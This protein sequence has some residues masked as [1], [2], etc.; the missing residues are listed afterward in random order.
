[1]GS[2]DRPGA[3]YSASATQV[4]AQPPSRIA[5]R[6]T[7][8]RA[9]APVVT[10]A[11][12]STVPE[13]RAQLW[14]TAVELHDI[15]G[16][17]EAAAT[18][19]DRTA[20]FDALCELAAVSAH[21][22]SGRAVRHRALALAGADPDLRVRALTCL[23]A[24]MIWTDLTPRLD[25]AHLRRGIEAAL[26]RTYPAEPRARLLIAAVLASGAEEAV[27]PRYRRACEALDL[28]YTLG[29]PELICAALDAVALTLTGPALLTGWRPIADELTRVAA[30]CGARHYRA[31]AQYLRFRAACRDTDLL[32][33]FHHAKHALEL[34]RGGP[35]RTQLDTLVAFAATVELLRG[36]L[37]A[38]ARDYREFTTRM[39]DSGVAHGP[40]TA[41][42]G[43]CAL[44]WA[45]GEFASM[46]DR[47]AYA[48]AAEPDRAA[49][50]YALALALAGD[51]DEARKLFHRH[52][53]APR[54]YFWTVMAAFRAHTA[55]ALGEVES[56]AL[57][58]ESLLP[59]SGTILGFDT[60]LAVFG[61]ADEVLAELAD[62]LGDEE[63]ALILR[64]R[65]E[66]VRDRV[67]AALEAIAA[68]E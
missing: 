50:P 38:A 61:P 21:D 45:K 40:S 58:Y 44:A 46:R 26:A 51:L 35:L 23:R 56:A 65:A 67:R 5:Q 13:R 20:M 49:Q 14:F 2:H 12:D 41:L 48:Y 27:A 32:A 31:L 63:S 60:G 68:G 28:A 29:D 8:A 57:L 34:A 55:I 53:V 24:P 18:T 64:G 1:M 62:L 16:H 3:S 4:L 6:R 9:L 36:D 30:A 47:L 42:I 39:S 11:R 25:N 17:S 54:Q 59:H 7:A 22:A 19:E 15:A 33:A 37:D 10:A 52:P 43:A 66:A